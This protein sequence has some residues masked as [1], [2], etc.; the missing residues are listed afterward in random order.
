[1]NSPT[2]FHESIDQS[3]MTH[4]LFLEKGTEIAWK[5]YIAGELLPH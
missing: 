5:I 4:R 1:M 2:L 3:I